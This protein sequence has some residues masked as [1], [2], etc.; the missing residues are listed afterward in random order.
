MAARIFLE[1]TTCRIK[2]ENKKATRNKCSDSF[3]NILD[4]FGELFNLFKV[5]KFSAFI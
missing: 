3:Y 4:L 5:N 2:V 1:I